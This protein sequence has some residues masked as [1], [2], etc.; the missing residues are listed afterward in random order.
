MTDKFSKYTGDFNIEVDG[1]EFE[2]DVR[3]SDVKSLMANQKE[4]M[5]EEAVENLVGVFKEILVRSYP[6]EDEEDIENFLTMNF[7]DFLMEFGDEMG[8]AEKSQLQETKSGLQKK[9][10]QPEQ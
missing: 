4:E 10:F 3:L 2:L 6:D 1:E 7:T 8:W 5:D 9:G